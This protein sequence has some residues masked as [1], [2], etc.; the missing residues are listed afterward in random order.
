MI[1][2]PTTCRWIIASH[3][4]RPWRATM[5]SGRASCFAV[6]AASDPPARRTL[7]GEAMHRSLTALAV[8]ALLA[9]SETTPAWGQRPAL[10]AYGDP[11]PPGAVARLGS[12][13]FRP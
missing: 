12:A 9:G 1:G 11:L 6:V 3:P 10:D 2:P 4:S 5:R 7:K 8:A 13:R